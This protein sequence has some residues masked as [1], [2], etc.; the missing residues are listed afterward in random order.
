MIACE[1]P[2]IEIVEVLVNDKNIKFGLEDQLKK[3]A[4]YYA[5]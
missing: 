1:R 4:L 2:N 3:N 5:I